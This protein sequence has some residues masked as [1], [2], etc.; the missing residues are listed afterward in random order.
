MWFSIARACRCDCD[1]NLSSASLCISMIASHLSS[2]TPPSAIVLSSIGLDT[3]EGIMG[4]VS[5]DVDP[6]LTF[7]RDS[8]AV[9]NPTA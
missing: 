4:E 8:V 2:A 5:S 3:S 7:V 1:T 9:A 6:V